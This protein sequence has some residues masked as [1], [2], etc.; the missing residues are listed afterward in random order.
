MIIDLP[1]VLP[2]MAAYEWTIADPAIFKF[3]YME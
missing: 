3:L 2:K 1:L